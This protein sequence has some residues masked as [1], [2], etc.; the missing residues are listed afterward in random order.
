M[1]CPK[2]GGMVGTRY[3]RS[4]KGWAWED[5]CLTCGK[6]WTLSVKQDPVP[7]TDRC[8]RQVARG[9][10]TEAGAPGMW[11]KPSRLEIAAE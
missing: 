3:V 9:S 6:T 2:C 11:N 4:S 10:Y 1:A 8:Y 5:H 7:Q